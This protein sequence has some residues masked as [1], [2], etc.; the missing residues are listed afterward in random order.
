MTPLLVLQNVYGKLSELYKCPSAVR[1]CYY[2]RNYWQ[3][4]VGKEMHKK[5]NPFDFSAIKVIEKTTGE[6]VRHL[7]MENSRATKYLMDREVRFT[8]VLTSSHYSV[9]LLVQS[10]LEIPFQVWIYLP[11]TQKNKE[12]VGISDKLITPLIC[13]RP[14]SFVISSFL[15]T[16]GEA[17]TTTANKSKKKDGGQNKTCTKWPENQKDISSFY[18]AK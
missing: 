5:D 15:Q 10:R 8:I 18:T 2:Y 11:P 3:P 9:S 16:S 17:S 7:S 1:G 4:V 14:E 13:F 12:L 6:A